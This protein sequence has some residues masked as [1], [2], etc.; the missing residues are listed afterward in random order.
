[1][2]SPLVQQWWKTQLCNSVID[3]SG[4]VDHHSS[5]DDSRAAHQ[6]ECEEAHGT[7]PENLSVHQNKHR[8]LTALRGTFPC[9]NYTLKNKGAL[10]LPASSIKPLQLIQNAAARLIFNE[11]KRTHVTPLFINLHWLPSIAARIK[12]KAL[13]FAY[14]TT[15]GSAPLYLNS[16]LQ[17]YITSRSLCSASERRFTVP[18][19]RDTKSLSQTFSWTVPIWWPA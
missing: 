9:P 6:L 5:R 7:A 3:A 17:T 10:G 14:R 4:R 13:M 15:S 8:P 18:S 2:A 1:M 11:P 19:Q 12:F 16:L